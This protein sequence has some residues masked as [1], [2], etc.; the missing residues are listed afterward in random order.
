VKGSDY[1]IFDET[2][3]AK[4]LIK[5]LYQVVNRFIARIFRCNRRTVAIISRSMKRYLDKMEIP[6][7]YNDII[8]SQF[9]PI[10]S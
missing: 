6:F 5:T 3:E 8:I 10:V 1:L 7:Y 9:R 4:R 2:L